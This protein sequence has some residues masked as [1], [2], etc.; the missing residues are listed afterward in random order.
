M[1]AI[2]DYLF[3]ILKSSTLIIAQFDDQVAFIAQSK[4]VSALQ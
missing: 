2:F 1:P 3:R 4:T